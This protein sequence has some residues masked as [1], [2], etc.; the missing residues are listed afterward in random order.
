M[1]KRLVGGI[2]GCKDKKKSPWHLSLFPDGSNIGLTVQC[3]EEAHRYTVTLTSIAMQRHQKNSNKNNAVHT[4]T[5]T[6]QKRCSVCVFFPFMLD[7][8]FVGRTSNI[9]IR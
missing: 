5:K 2:I 9:I 1:S 7:I 3:R 4:T 8:K 6:N